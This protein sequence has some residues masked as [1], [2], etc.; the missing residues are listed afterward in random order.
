MVHRGEKVR[1]G[2]KAGVL[3]ACTKR[4]L[5]ESGP[6]GIRSA[7]GQ[8]RTF[9]EKLEDS[10]GQLSQSDRAVF[11]ITSGEVRNAQNRQER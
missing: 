2:S 11:E 4:Q 7:Y 5:S 8:G 3:C 1:S 9:L 10:V 6:R